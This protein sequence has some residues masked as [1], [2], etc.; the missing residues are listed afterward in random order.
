MKRK[1][2]KTRDTIIAAHEV[3]LVVTEEQE[4]QFIAADDLRRNAKN[5]A[6]A[7]Q[8]MVRDAI[9]GLR[10]VGGYCWDEEEISDT[11]KE[12]KRSLRPSKLWKDYK[13][14]TAPEKFDYYKGIVAQ[15]VGFQ[16]V[17]DAEDALARY[18][19]K[20]AGWPRFE[21]RGKHV[22]FPAKRDGTDW[23]KY[24]EN[25]KS[26]GGYRQY[27]TFQVS[28]IKGK[29]KMRQRLR[30]NAK[31]EDIIK[32]TIKLKAG[33]WFA[34]FVIDT[35]KPIPGKRDINTIAGVDIGYRQID[36]R[37]LDEDN[38]DNVHTGDKQLN[39]E[40]WRK[41]ASVCYAET[42]EYH[43]Y[44]TPQESKNL[45]KGIKR[46]SRKMSRR[47]GNKKGE[48]PSRRFTRAKNAK[49][50]RE[51]QAANKRID[52]QH[53]ASS[54]IIRHTDLLRTETLN[55]TGMGSKGGQHKKGMNRNR[56][57]GS[58]GRF[59]TMLEYKSQWHGVTIEKADMW[60][61]SSQICPQCSQ[62][63]KQS[64]QETFV[65]LNQNCAHTGDREQ[66]ASN[67]LAHKRISVGYADKRKN[68]HGK[69]GTFPAVIPDSEIAEGCNTTAKVASQD[70]ISSVL[71]E[72]GGI[73]SGKGP[74]NTN[75]CAGNKFSNIE[76]E[77]NMR[78]TPKQ[79]TLNYTDQ[80]MSCKPTARQIETSA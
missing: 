7:H 5:W 42:G 20:I 46:A 52:A 37:Q 39:T 12:L 32:V 67:N 59:Q 44:L 10:S 64:T 63:T 22:R 71:T 23:V 54:D 56:D 75:I 8:N 2:A 13:N 57:D 47:R 79:T 38:W 31:A 43:L 24:D 53:K 55:H 68:E 40:E 41:L 21:K 69:R 34:V 49:A 51:Q 50:R 27:A 25:R 65:C 61:P 11:V 30:W 35:R 78:A 36:S 66:I 9:K 62:Q 1:S 19:D 76:N 28:M 33:R 58:L 48:T 80:L 74:D 4:K 15:H 60:Y 70:G 72:E 6:I 26:N 18:F 16:G 14:T 3:E 73:E 29:I 45:T 77:A 17:A